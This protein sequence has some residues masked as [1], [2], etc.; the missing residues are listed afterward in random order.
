MLGLTVPLLF[1]AAANGDFAARLEGAV[2]GLGER[3]SL[4]PVRT[5]TVTVVALDDLEPARLPELMPLLESAAAVGWVPPFPYPQA[6]VDSG[7]VKLVQ[8]VAPQ[9]RS[10]RP[11]ADLPSSLANWPGAV[12]STFSRIPGV[13]TGSPP[14]LVRAE[15]GPLPLSA[16]EL[17]LLDF[18]TGPLEHYRAPLLMRYGNRLVPSLALRLAS[19]ASGD[20]LGPDALLTP[21]IR[22]GYLELSTDWAYRVYPRLGGEPPPVV[23]AADL[24][25]GTFDPA[26]QVVLLGLLD[27]QAAEPVLFVSDRALPPVLAEAHLTAALLDQNLFTIPGW[28]AWAQWGALAVVALMLAL[29]LPRLA[30]GTGTVLVV[31]LVFVALTVEFGLLSLNNTLV[32]LVLPVVALIAGSLLVFAKR[33][34]DGRFDRLGA[35]LAASNRL[36]AQSY[37]AQGQLDAALE[38]YLRCPPDDELKDRLYNLALDFERRRQF[39]KAAGVFEKLLQYDPKFSDAEERLRRNRAVETRSMLGKSHNSALPETIIL[40]NTG[41]ARPTLGRYELERELGRGAMGL[42]YLGRD[43]KIGRTVA[44]KTMALSQEFDPADLQTVRERF[45]REAETAG[46]LDH[47]NIVTVYDVGE[48]HDLAYMAMD[49]LKGQSLAAWCRTEEL[50]PFD[51]VMEIA[52]Q[53]A[54]ALDYAHRHNVVHRDIKPANIVYDR[55]LRTLKVTDFGVACLTDM[56]KTRTGTVLGSPSYMSP[57]QVAGRQVDGRADLF[58]L[59]VTVFQLLTGDLPFKG[60]SLASLMYQ[61]T[62]AKHADIR[63]VRPD[64]PSCITR[65]MNKALQKE[66]ERRYQ[67]GANMAVALRRCKG[68]GEAEA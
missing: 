41:I 57:E 19:L 3:F 50:L 66:A 65:I 35:E 14:P 39:T 62:S 13:L 58:S 9:Q 2:V 59:G 28:G 20:P 17:A 44:I 32:P 47:P 56:S 55:D 54:D 68:N 46:R 6:P 60:D 53:V 18:R 22:V 40:D 51:E 48:E 42:V 26:G 11:R 37:Q 10:A 61:I 16:G 49:Y 52:A 23:P 12:P 43:P 67:S 38:R 45:F 4:A 25:A 33:L 30:I 34:V 8:G 36:L 15:A 27:P 29:V 24:L 1:L 64:L 63:T 7:A 31:L 5:A 21:G